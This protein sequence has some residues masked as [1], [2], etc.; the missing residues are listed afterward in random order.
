MG[1][2]A[3][4]VEEDDLIKEKGVVKNTSDHFGGIGEKRKKSS[5]GLSK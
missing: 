2:F 4:Y 1:N 5:I 3:W